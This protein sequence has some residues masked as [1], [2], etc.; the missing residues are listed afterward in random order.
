MSAK[1][2]KQLALGLDIPKSTAQINADIKSLQSKLDTVHINTIFTTQN[3]ELAIFGNTISSI[4]EKWNEFQNAVNK[5]DGKLFGEN[6][7]FASLLNDKRANMQIS[8]DVSSQFEVFKEKFNTSSLSAEALAE[9]FQNVDQRIIDYA[10][11]CKNGEMTTEGFKESINSMSFSAKAG[12]AAL[13]VFAS[14][15]NM[16]AGILI[17]KALEIAVTAIDNYINRVEK[18]N[19]AMHDAVGEYE[20]A[21][22]SLDG[23]NSKIKEHNETIDDLLSKD[24]LTYVEQGQLEELQAITKE[25]LLQQDIEERRTDNASKE[26]ADKTVDAFEKQ[27]GSYDLTEEDLQEKLALDHFPTPE[28]KDDILGN[29]SSYIRANELLEQAKKDYEE[30]LA[31]GEDTTWL[32]YDRQHLIDMA[33]DYSQLIDNNIGDLLE[34]QMALEDE[35]HNAVENRA[36]D[37]ESLTSSEKDAITTYEQIQ[38]ILKTVYKYTDQNAWN[39]MEIEDLFNTQGIEKT[40]EELI[41]MAKAGELTPETLEQYPKLNNAIKNSEIFFENGQT[42]AKVFCNEI[43]ACADESADLMD[44]FGYVHSISSFEDAWKSLSLFDNDAA[45]KLSASLM[46]LAENGSLT[47]ETFQSADSTGYFKSLGI[48]ADEAVTKINELADESKQLSSMSGQ[49]SSMANALNTKQENG[50]VSADTLSGFN[51]KVQGLDSWD[52]FRQVLGSTTSSYDECCSAAN[53]LADEWL[54]SNNFLAQLTE[55]NKEFYETQLEEMGISNAHAV[56][57]EALTLKN[58]EL[59]LSKQ[60]L[61]EEGKEL[62]SVSEIEQAEFIANAVAAGTCSQQYAALYLQKILC[63]ENWLDS[64]TDINGLL[65]LAE[66]AGI[67]GSAII[68]L[69]SLKTGYDTAVANGDSNAAI[70]INNQMQTLK[71]QLANEAARLGTG[72]KIDFGKIGGGKPAAKSAGQEAGKSYADGLKDEISRLN[73]VIGAIGK[74]ISGQI[75]LYNDQKDAAVDALEAQKEAAEE[76]LEAEK[77]LIQEQIDAKQDEIDKINEASEARKNELDLQK[78]QYELARMQNQR[79]ILQ[80][81]EDKGLHYVTD[82]SGIRDAR[83]AVTE[84]QENIKIAG[85]EKEISDLEATLDSL[86]R[87]IEESNNYY[88]N[89]IGQTEQYWDS[90]I[91]GLEDYKSRWEEL[92]EIEEH[93][94]ITAQLEQ[95]GISSTDVL[96]MSESAFAGFKEGYLGL[97]GEMYQGSE[98]MLDS[99]SQIAGTDLSGLSNSFE[100]AAASVGSMANAINGSEGGSAASSS[101]GLQTNDTSS[102]GSLKSAIRDQTEAAVADL[103]T[104]KDLFNGDEGLKGA[105]QEVICK[106]GRA[107]GSEGSDKNSQGSQDESNTLMAAIQHQTEQALDEE[108]GIPAQ[109]RAWEELNQP[110]GEAAEHIAALQST[111]EEMDG[112]TFTATLNIVGNGV[113]MP[114]EEISA[115]YNTSSSDS[116]H[117]LSPLPAGSRT[118]NLIQKFQQF[119]GKITEGSGQIMTRAMS[120]LQ[121]QADQTARDIASANILQN[122]KNNQ[123]VTMTIGDIHLAGVQDVNGLAS[124]IKSHLPG[125]MMQGYFKS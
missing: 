121:A 99:L 114:S 32:D 100:N 24:K 30:A 61:A 117:T 70:A 55:Q 43:N 10:K 65:V 106:I 19:E 27:Y 107:S 91:K 119:S 118:S 21:K 103:T 89:L 86:D 29:V 45:K 58:E 120:G 62:A 63:N 110:L 93:A 25:L 3:R 68:Q 66:A 52:R 33:D 6:G 84:A 111:L 59:A 51:A 46:E 67:A 78:K 97:L 85:M 101:S 73:D 47:I 36:A 108:T 69:S 92:A 60:Y 11:T 23:I 1:N 44:S 50:F 102:G 81:S 12:K 4:K 20:S 104:Q 22:A 40:K 90:L 26:A 18:A 80:Y 54:N 109:K 95:M 125:M 94:K 9:Q 112:K 53:A 13:Q 122:N 8:D 39:G 2:D 83:E 87:K 88:D 76:A 34:M 17:D 105:V 79:T 42:A 41:A 7:A 15:G 74:I 48:S 57:Q 96:N 49:I 31:N 38:D 56:I 16:V 123:P 71:T 72:V 75:D 113:S 116:R 82:T 14:A 64:A 37:A 35:Y 115:V 5:S 77:A 124:A 98:Q 28:G